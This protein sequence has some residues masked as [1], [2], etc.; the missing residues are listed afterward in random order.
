MLHARTHAKDNRTARALTSQQYLQAACHCARLHIQQ[1]EAACKS[2]PLAKPHS[3]VLSRVGNVS[4]VTWRVDWKLRQC[5]VSSSLVRHKEGRN[6]RIACTTTSCEVLWGAKDWGWRETSHEVWHSAC[7]TFSSHVCDRMFQEGCTRHH[8]VCGTAWRRSLLL[9]VWLLKQLS[10][11]HASLPSTFKVL[12]TSHLRVFSALQ[13]T[14]NWQ[15][16]LQVSSKVCKYQ[17]KLQNE[18]VSL[19]TLILFKSTSSGSCKRLI[20]HN[21]VWLRNWT[22]ASLFPV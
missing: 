3:L 1:R 6:A 8:F 13:Q 11:L 9:A 5:S 10:I 12:Q 20:A 18:A 21:I 17:R 19:N 15:I 2:A 16:L 14:A 4:V 22:R 7:R